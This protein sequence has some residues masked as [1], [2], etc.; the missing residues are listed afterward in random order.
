MPQDT[1]SGPQEL[2]SPV[3]DYRGGYYI[4]MGS[5][6]FLFHGEILFPVKLRTPLPVLN[7]RRDALLDQVGDALDPVELPR[8]LLHEWP[9]M[10][11]LCTLV[12]PD[13]T[14]LRWP[15]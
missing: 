4:T 14:R 5:I 9:S 2:T 13:R 7:L 11:S 8:S 1:P 3:G 15:V 12:P 10:V 6:L